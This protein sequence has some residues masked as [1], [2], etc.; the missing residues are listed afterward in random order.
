[1]TSSHSEGRQPADSKLLDDVRR[2]RRPTSDRK[3]YVTPL[4]VT[5]TRHRYESLLRVSHRKVGV[6]VWLVRNREYSPSL[7]TK[8]AFPLFSF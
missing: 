3:V 5:A 6:R 8:V 4:R 2:V 1:M 7:V